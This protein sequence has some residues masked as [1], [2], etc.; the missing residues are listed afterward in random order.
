MD[1]TITG[2]EN[3]FSAGELVEYNQVGNVLTGSADGADVF[4]VTLNADGSFTFDLLGQLDHV[5][6]DGENVAA[7]NFG[8]SGTPSSDVV[9][10]IADFDQDAA[11]GL[12]D[13]IITQTVTVD[14]TD[15][16]P[17]VVAGDAADVA[18]TV[19]L[20]EDDT[21]AG[22]DGSDSTSA[23]GDLG[24]AGKDLFTVDV[25]ADADGATGG[26]SLTY[27]DFDFAITGPEGL[28]SNE[29]PI[30]YNQVGNILTASA[31][32]ESVF[33]VT[34]NADGTYTFDLQGNIDH[35]SGAGQNDTV[36]SFGLSGTVKDGV[37][38]VDGDGDAVD[39]SNATVSHGFSVEIVDDVPVATVNNDVIG[40]ATVGVVNEDDLDGG[41]DLIAGV[42]GQIIDV[43]DGDGDDLV[44]SGDLG[45]AGRDLVTIDYG[46]DGPADGAPTTLQYDDFNYTITG[47]TGLTSQGA[48]ISYS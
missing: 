22:T 10:A 18:E 42:D 16:I 43:A 27:E 2:P 47:P 8:L 28:T 31:G 5:S 9:A 15:D 19:S 20:D 46:A 1:W 33:T 24:L 41:N 3:L 12:A 25:G 30:T 11:A 23:T 14:V 45:L 36:L 40:A 39:L 35:A 26:S 6:G 7:L 38:I 21:A 13:Q 34:L 37:E 29:I 44:T 17:V 32:S 4:T 48:P